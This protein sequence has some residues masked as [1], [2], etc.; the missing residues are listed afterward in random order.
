MI[1]KIIARLILS[2]IIT[3]LYGMAVVWIWHHNGM[4][5]NEIPTPLA[6]LFTIIPVIG[7]FMYLTLSAKEGK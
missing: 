7:G 6:V 4:G 1:P 5:Q 2:H 3:L